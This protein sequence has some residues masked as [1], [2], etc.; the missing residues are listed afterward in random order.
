[1]IHGTLQLLEPVTRRGFR[2][3]I[4]YF[5]R[6]LAED[7]G[8]RAIGIV[9]S[10]TGT[11]GTLGLKAIKGAEGLAIVQDPESAQYDGMPRS[12]IGTGL[13]D[14]ILTPEAMPAQLMAYV[15]QAFNQTIEPQNVP[16]SQPSDTL[17]KIFVL[18]L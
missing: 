16:L 9:L 12:A 13:I 11:D 17:Q 5:F 8:E 18:L 14:Y 10:G 1:M 7:Q 6:S 15:Q 4:D 2:L 3:P